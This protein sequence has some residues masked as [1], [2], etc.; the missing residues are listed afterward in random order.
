MLFSSCKQLSN[1]IVKNRI[2]VILV[3]QKVVSFYLVSKKQF[4]FYIVFD[5]T[6]SS[7]HLNIVLIS[8][9]SIKTKWALHF[10]GSYFIISLVKMKQF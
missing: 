9:V 7:M 1:G 8:L 5:F 10:A 6:F 4:Q 3:F 2:W